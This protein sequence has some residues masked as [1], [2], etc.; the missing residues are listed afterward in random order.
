MAKPSSETYTLTGPGL[1][2]LLLQDGFGAA[3]SR[4][5]TAAQHPRSSTPAEFLLYGENGRL[6]ARVVR[7]GNGHARVW[8]SDRGVEDV[9][10]AYSPR[11]SSSRRPEPPAASEGEHMPGKTTTR[12][13]SSAK[14][15][16]SS[17][18]GSATARSSRSSAA[19]A[20]QH[21]SAK[22]A[23]RDV[24][25]AAGKPL[26][27][28]DIVKGVLAHNGVELKGKTPAATIAAI[29][30]VENAKENGLFVRVEKGTYDLRD[31]KG[32]ADAAA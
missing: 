27:T 17:A 7:D 22:D 16:S 15:R 24:L 1:E 28:A 23:V 13:R 20:M 19:A 26:A 30:S 9:A 12:K 14:K 8:A 3:V 18:S 11:A 21:V 29:L 2:P 5:L 31:R 25:K 6:V 32:T 10:A 4:A